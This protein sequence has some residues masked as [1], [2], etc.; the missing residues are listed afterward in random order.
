MS[1]RR[2]ALRQILVKRSLVIGPVTLASGKQ[3]TYYFDCRTTTLDPD[4]A[5]LIADQ[6]LDIIDGLPEP[7]DAVGGLTLGA[8]PII[9]AVMMR[10]L[11][12]GRKLQSFYVRKESKEHGTQKLVENPPPAGSRV[13]LVEDVVTTGGSVLKAFDQAEKI[14]CRVIAVISLLDR[15][16]G[17]GDAIRSRCPAF[18]SLFTLKDFPELAAFLSRSG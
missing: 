7:P 11:E 8:D 13:V 1:S 10:G 14:G 15:L 3:S 2:E 18:Y 17:G 16:D 5:S 9:G 4:G 12:R 6:M